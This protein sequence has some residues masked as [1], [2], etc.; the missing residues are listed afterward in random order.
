MFRS[1]VDLPSLKTL[2]MCFVSF[3]DMKD[4]MKLL[5]GCPMLENLKTICVD[6]NAGVTAGGYFKPL[7]KLINADINLFEVPLRAVYNV[8]RLYVFWVWYMRHPLLLEFI[9]FE[10]NTCD[11][12]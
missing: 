3:E 8:Q 11:I 10:I 7:S 2:Y 12:V 4:L 1:S 6:A 5:S 9:Y